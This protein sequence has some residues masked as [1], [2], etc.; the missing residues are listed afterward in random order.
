MIGKALNNGDY[1]LAGAIAGKYVA[2]AGVGY[3]GLDTAR[4]AVFKR[5]P[6]TEADFFLAMTDQLM[7]AAFMNK[8][9]TQSFGK[10]TGNPVDFLIMSFAPPGGLTE[11]AGQDIAQF[12]KALG[13]EDEELPTKLLERTPLF[14]DFYKY[15]WSKED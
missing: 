11:A 13:D 8:L 12:I 14:G 3:A 6:K 7:G 4:E 5:E 2:Y 1:A 9:D 10:F 15:W